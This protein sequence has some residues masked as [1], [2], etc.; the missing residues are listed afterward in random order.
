[1]GRFALAVATFTVAGL[2][3]GTAASQIGTQ[4]DAAK[5]RRDPPPAP[6]K[7]AWTR[8]G[9]VKPTP[10]D[11]AAAA[12]ARI[13]DCR[14]LARFQRDFNRAPFAEQV[15][16]KRRALNCDAP[17]P[18][19]V[20]VEPPATP[21]PFPSPL[22]PP[23]TI[24]DGVVSGAGGSPIEFMIG[25]RLIRLAGVIGCNPT[26]D[27]TELNRRLSGVLICRPLGSD[28]QCFSR[29]T[30]EDLASVAVLHG[31]AQPTGE[32]YENEFYK[33]RELV[34]QGKGAN[35]LSGR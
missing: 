26:N 7:P 34:R 13:R 8:P 6:A 27:R 5:R 15:A 2:L 16:Q 35:C 3:T 20:R 25:K 17:L 23:R 1:M 33:W 4:V 14:G 18:E 29:E 12:F 21:I 32:S 28:Y 11:K 10:E 9:P 31:N 30:K 22:P 24:V 19:R